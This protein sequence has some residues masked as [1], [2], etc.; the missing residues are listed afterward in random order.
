MANKDKTPKYPN[1]KFFHL[2]DKINWKAQGA[3]AMEFAGIAVKVIKNTD[4]KDFVE[5]WKNNF[6]ATGKRIAIEPFAVESSLIESMLVDFSTPIT[7]AAIRSLP[8]IAELLANLRKAQDNFNAA[9]D[10]QTANAIDKPAS[11]TELKKDMLL[12]LN[13]RLIPY[14][15]T[16]MMANPDVFG[17]FAKQTE[18]EIDRANGTVPQRST[19]E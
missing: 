5:L 18:V 10:K 6:K 16:M 4:P 11:A 1:P 17:T 14:L 12:L 7:I 8:G 9:S 3:N 13:D 19:K 15:N 2:K